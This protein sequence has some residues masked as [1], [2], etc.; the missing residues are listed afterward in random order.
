MEEE[1]TMNSK[2]MLSIIGALNLVA[3]AFVFVGCG[4]PITKDDVV[5]GG[6]AASGTPS[7][8]GSGTTP[9]GTNQNGGGSGGAFQM[10]AQ[11]KMIYDAA[12]TQLAQTAASMTIPASMIATQLQT[13]NQSS[14]GPAGFKVVDTK[15]GQPIAQNTTKEAL[16]ARFK[17]QAK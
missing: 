2:K 4:Q 10:T 5:G 12:I 1:I 8:P 16:K 15:A 9:G 6:G 14:F 11:Q 3:A 13:Y 17:A 7:T